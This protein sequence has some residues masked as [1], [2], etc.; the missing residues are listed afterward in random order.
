M[1]RIRWSIVFTGGV[2]GFWMA[3]DG[4]ELTTA[5]C[6][7]DEEL[8]FF[9]RRNWQGGKGHGFPLFSQ[10]KSFLSCHFLMGWNFGDWGRVLCVLLKA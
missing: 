7:F 8:V 9:R 4:K 2:R 3:K 5:D 6:G 10:D 1:S